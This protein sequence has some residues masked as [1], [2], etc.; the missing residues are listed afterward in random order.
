MT[1]A[2]LLRV[3]SDDLKRQGIE[4]AANDAWLLLQ[5]AAVLTRTRYLLCSGEEVPAETVDRYRKMVRLRG[6]HIPLQHLTGEQEFFGF[7]FRVNEQV[8]IPRQDTETLVEEAR[9]RIRPGDAVLDL[10]TGSGCIIIS[11]AKLIP[12]LRATGSDLSKEA[13]TVARE[14]AANLGADVSFVESDLFEKIQGQFDCIVSNPPYIPS[15][16]IGSLMEEVRLHEPLM[17]L[18]GGADGLDFYRRIVEGS[19]SFL[20]SGGFLLFEVGCEQADSVCCLMEPF[21]QEIEII[22][23]LAGRNRV[24]AGRRC[25]PP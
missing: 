5:E 1:F 16:E 4:E 22:R 11:L 2:Q 15:G 14:N 24:V 20:K 9:K 6:Q 21:Y 7:S 10:C 25:A 12:G 3:A 19:L 8:L 23:D 17:A 13:L 18:D